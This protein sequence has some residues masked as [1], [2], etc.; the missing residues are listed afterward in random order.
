MKKRPSEHITLLCTE[1]L[2][3]EWKHWRADLADLCG[4][5]TQWMGH[6]VLQGPMEKF[7]IVTKKS[8]SL[9]LKLMV[10]ISQYVSC[11]QHIYFV[12]C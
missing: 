9:I 3:P 4:P 6:I 1:L 2:G 8:F 7:E 10:S 12:E 5:S 11:L